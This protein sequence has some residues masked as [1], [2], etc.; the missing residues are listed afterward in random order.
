MSFKKQARTFRRE[1]DDYTDVINIQAD[2]YNDADQGRFTVNLGVYYPA[3]ADITEAIPVNG[4]PKEYDCTVRERIGVLMEPHSDSWWEID[5][6]SNE[7]D[8]AADLAKAVKNF[9]LPWLDCLSDLNVVQRFAAEHY[10]TPVSA[11][12]ALHQGEHDGA[13]DYLP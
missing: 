13:Q 8:T 11:G 9:G 5:R 4:A 1:H 10:Q 2:R 7:A 3:I 12:I 6:W